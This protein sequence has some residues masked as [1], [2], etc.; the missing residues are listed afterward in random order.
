MSIQKIPRL[1]ADEAAALIHHG[2]QIGFS[3]FTPAGAAK[4]I[5]KAIAARAKEQHAK[6]LP[7][8]IR[9]LTGASTGPSLDGELAGAEAVSFRAPYQS[10]PIMRKSI[11]EGRTEFFDMHLSLVPQNARYGFLGKF[12]WAIVEAADVTENGDI[13][14][15][16]SVGA[17]PSYCRMADKILVELNRFHPPQL[18]GFHD[19]YEPEDPP[20]RKPI[21]LCSVRDRIGGSVVKV[22]PRKIVGVVETDLPD[23]TGAFDPATEV[24]RKIGQNVAEFLASEVRL[25]RIPKPF[26]PIQSGVGNIANSVLGAL[27]DHP[28]IPVFE[29]YS[30][31]IQDSVIALLRKEKISFASGCSLTIAPEK[32]KAFYSD[33]E[34]FRPR[35]V[36]RPQEISNH[37]E[38]IR[39][40]GIIS[41]NTAIEVD[42]AGNVNSTHILGKSMMNGIGGSGDFARNSFLSIFTCP[43]TAKDNKISAIVPM[44]SHLDH[45]EHSVQVIVTENGV[46]DLRGKS[47]KEHARLIIDHCAHPDYRESLH[48]YLRMSAASHQPQ[49]LSAAFMMH[50]QFALTGSMQGVS[51][52]RAEN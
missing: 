30:E 29:M 45:S 35:I 16:S 43:S 18:R 50:E 14:L 9:V 38:I 12:N 25:G 10:D 36:L 3:G 27:G 32:L 39:R 31:V 21:P 37:P 34:Y 1:T 20:F 41:V 49:V 6:G 23:E 7:F 5:P 28:D 22:D 51:W 33:I 47:P 8:Q 24:T 48:Q 40:L 42:I 15:T 19:I 11:N 2:D 44:V 46:A 13:V 4:A 52:P 17:S 26:L